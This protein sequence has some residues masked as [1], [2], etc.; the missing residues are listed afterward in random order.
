MEKDRRLANLESRVDDLE[1]YTRINSVIVTG[2]QIK[3][4]SQLEWCMLTTRGRRGEMDAD[5]T[6]Q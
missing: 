3:L 4:R 6:E 2:L 5:S 1:Q